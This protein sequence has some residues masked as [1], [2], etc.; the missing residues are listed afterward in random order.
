[1]LW[2]KFTT[3]VYFNFNLWKI[4]VIFQFFYYGKWRSF[5]YKPLIP[6]LGLCRALWSCIEMQYGPST[7]WSLLKSYYIYIYTVYIY[8]YIL[9]IYIYTVYIYIYCI[10]I[11]IYIY[12]YIVSH[13]SEYTLH[14]FVNV[15][16]YIF[17]WQHWRNYTLLQCK[18]VSVQLV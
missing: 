17:M 6:Q 18:V 10:Y 16:L 5:C 14:I 13:R 12:I 8:I 15:L 7:H 4:I 11:Y 2:L 9:Y 3:F 1:M